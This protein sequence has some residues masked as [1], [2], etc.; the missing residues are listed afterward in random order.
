MGKPRTYKV[1]FRIAELESQD[2]HTVL[3]VKISGIRVRAVLDTGASHSCIDRTFVEQ[4]LPGNRPENVQGVN[5]GIGG[6]DFEVLATTV[7][8]FRIGHFRIERLEN[9]AV[10]DFKHINEAYKIVGMK[11]VHFILGNDFLVMH[12]A[13]IDYTLNRMYFTK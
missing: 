13:I 10:I 11:P 6:S 7:E 12:K 1:G 5:A 4:R 2:F 8:D 3:D 9:L